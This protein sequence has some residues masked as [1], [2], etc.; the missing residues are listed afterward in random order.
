MVLNRERNLLSGYDFAKAGYV[1]MRH[2]GE[3]LLLIPPEKT[4]SRL[5]L[6]LYFPQ[7]CK[8]RLAVSALR[9]ANSLGMLRRVLRKVTASTCEEVSGAQ[10]FTQEDLDAGRIG[11]QLCTSDHGSDCVVAVRAGATPQTVKWAPRP[12]ADDLD[13]EARIMR[14]L[15][16]KGICGVPSVGSVGGD[17]AS[18]WF[19][20][21]YLERVD[22]RSVTDGRAV[23]L[24]ESWMSEEKENLLET[25]LGR[26]LWASEEWTPQQKCLDRLRKLKISRAVMH[27]DFV[28]WNFRQEA[29][30]LMAINWKWAREDGLGGID[31]CYGL[32]Q[33]ALLVKKLPP[34]EALFYVRRAVESSVCVD[35]LEACGWGGAT[36]LWLKTGVFYR[37]TRQ[38]CPEVLKLLCSF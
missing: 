3:P 36:E 24:L 6:G 38:P 22:V 20:M 28:P 11:I 16:G 12:A 21:A 23:W 2:K 18:S 5:T 10:P 7:G 14:Q 4:P 29:A 26:E 25:D 1:V 9:I 32:L 17:E 13:Q 31:L 30:Q 37:H 33:E 19:E 8:A 35:Y 27:G 15:S 34:R